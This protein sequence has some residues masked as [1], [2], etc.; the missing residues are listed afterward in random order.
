[1]G[2]FGHDT[3]DNP[4]S[5]TLFLQS[6][7]QLQSNP[8]HRSQ[9]DA[10]QSFKLDNISPNLTLYELKELIQDAKGIKVE[11][12]MISNIRQTVLSA[13]G[14]NPALSD[15]KTLAEL[16]IVNENTKLM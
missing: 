12:Q 15:E 3:V 6:V 5:I 4:I 1:M 9:N 2:R 7:G 14:N 8:F 11:Q 13:G 16:G 10:A